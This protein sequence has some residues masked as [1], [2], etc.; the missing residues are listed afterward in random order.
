MAVAPFT[1]AWIEMLVISNEWQRLSVAPFTG[2]WIE[3]RKLSR[4]IKKA[5]VAPFT[6]AWI[7]IAGQ[8][9]ARQTSAGRSLH[10]SVD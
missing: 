6:G 9:S 2:A 1:G 3:I 8:T 4:Y 5:C 10:G 7:E